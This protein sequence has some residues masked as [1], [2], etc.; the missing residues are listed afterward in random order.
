[1]AL[2]KLIFKLWTVLNVKS[3]HTKPAR[4][5]V[6]PNLAR[7]WK[8]QMTTNYLELIQTYS[9]LA[10]ELRRSAAIPGRSSACVKDFRQGHFCK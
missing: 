8:R 1:M 2:V 10:I 3:P 7:W 6:F 4:T 9:G 5:P